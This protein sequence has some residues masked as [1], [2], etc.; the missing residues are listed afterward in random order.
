M[1]GIVLVDSTPSLDERLIEFQAD[2][3]S[4]VAQTVRGDIPAWKSFAYEAAAETGLLRL[5]FGNE[6]NAAAFLP[7]SLD[8][9]G[10]EFSGCIES[11]KQ[12]EAVKGIGEKPLVVI[13]AGKSDDIWKDCQRELLKLSSNSR[14]VV[15]E[16]SDHGI[17]ATEPEI[18][19]ESIR[20]ALE[21][22]NTG[23]LLSDIGESKTESA[24]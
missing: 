2:D 11:L 1:A 8:A 6:W 20:D 15:A 19:I 23:K 22:S 9:V 7:Q 10:R 17:E 13:C 24:Q 18:I 14:F 4:A 16:K 3:N 5:A 21:S 12:A